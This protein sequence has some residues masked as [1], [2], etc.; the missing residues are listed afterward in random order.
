MAGRDR[1]S[2]ASKPADVVGSVGVA[3]LLHTSCLALRGGP[4]LGQESR[5]WLRR[6]KPESFW[7]DWGSLALLAGVWIA[8]R[9]LGRRL[10]LLSLAMFA[11]NGAVIRWG[12]SFRGYALA[13]LLILSTYAS[14]WR[15]VQ[16][17]T[18]RSVMTAA[19]A[20]ILSVNIVFQDI[21]LLFAMCIGGSLVGVHRR[22]WKT[23]LAVLGI[24]LAA[25]LSLLPYTR[26]VSTY[27]NFNVQVPELYEIPAVL[28]ML[29]LTL[30][31]GS[32][33]MRWI[34]VGIW[35]VALVAGLDVVATRGKSA[36]DDV[37]G[38]IYHTTILALGASAFV[39][40][41]N[42]ASMQVNPWHCIV[43]VP[44][45][46]VAA[47]ALIG[48]VTTSIAGRV[49]RVVAVIGITAAAS[50]VALK[51]I[52]VRQTNI[53]VIAEIVARQSTPG[54]LIV[55]NPWF[56][57]LTFQHYYSG[58]A[59]WTTVPPLE[60]IGIHRYDLLMEKMASAEPL[61]PLLDSISTR[62]SAG[63]RVWIVGH[64]AA[65]PRGQPSASVLPAPNGP[66]GWYSGDYVVAWTLQLGHFIDSHGVTAT[67]VD[68]HLQQP[69]SSYE[70]AALYS[71]AGW[72]PSRD[73]VSYFFEPSCDID[74]LGRRRV[75]HLGDG[76]RIVAPF[77]VWHVHSDGSPVIPPDFP[78]E[79][80]R[81]HRIDGATENPNR[82]GK[83]RV[84]VD[85]KRR[86]TT[87]SGAGN[88]TA[89][90]TLRSRAQTQ[91]PDRPRASA[92]RRAAP[93][94][95]RCRPCRP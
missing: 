19:A 73:G 43:V 2:H 6:W 64:F 48:L 78:L 41:S 38:A 49:A 91:S 21:P 81:V 25:A 37:A 9:L 12:D 65:P 44:I 59:D 34:W 55:V 58:T 82:C 24:G 52:A 17:A 90:L 94:A 89:A 20:A 23:V 47:D 63:K 76:I 13:S 68:L 33:V 66:H 60:E 54:D 57:G 51:E 18:P 61:R 95:D 67:P 26:I 29:T 14:V 53:D 7:H 42:A 1:H 77:H 86:Q 88:R 31:S 87:R 92:R 28:S 46:A 80:A 35:I 69:I 15:V 74:R 16:A 84:V 40:F 93:H 36:N 8:T 50:P 30:T 3:Q 27:R 79:N 70:A 11:L 75:K 56:F 4:T 5:V 62:L 72:R 45:L 83:F 10:P 22:D 85:T 32:E 39:V 71:L